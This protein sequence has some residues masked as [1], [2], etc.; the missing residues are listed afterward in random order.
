MQAMS[1]ITCLWPGLPQLWWRG[2]WRPLLSAAGFA[3][4]LNIGLA[5][6]FVWTEWSPTWLLG[7]GWLGIGLFWAISVG[8]GSRALPGLLGT[9]PDIAVEDLFRQAQTEYLS[10]DWFEAE[11]LLQQVL[12]RSEH[13]ADARLLLATLYRHT[14]RSDE[15]RQCLTR[16]ECMD[17]ADRWTLEIARE[18][19]LLE[20]QEEVRE[21]DPVHEGADSSK[22]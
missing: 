6:T 2:G 21:K 15:A 22:G 20:R 14:G 3:V 9:T 18:R 19:R 11:K 16:L 7:V 12:G 17:K 13:D 1:R 10:K 4:L 8:L 5:A